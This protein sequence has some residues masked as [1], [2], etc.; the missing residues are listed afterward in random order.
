MSNNESTIND[1]SQAYLIPSSAVFILSNV[2]SIVRPARY[3]V[4][5]G[6]TVKTCIFSY[7]PPSDT[8][9]IGGYCSCDE[10]KLRKLRH[11]QGDLT[12]KPQ[13]E[14]CHGEEFPGWRERTIEAQLKSSLFWTRFSLS[15][16]D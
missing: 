15:K 8:C 11:L 1:S 13:A 3:F 10:E 9:E 16:F 7:C 6:I 5:G 14:P 4:V 12:P 2:A